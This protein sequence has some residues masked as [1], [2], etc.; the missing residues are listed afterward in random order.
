MIFIRKKAVFL[1]DKLSLGLTFLLWTTVSVAQNNLGELLDAGA[2]RLSADEFRQEV[3]QQPMQGPTIAGSGTME[4][5]FT[6]SGLVQGRSTP[7]YIARPVMVGF[8]GEWTF[9]DDGTV[10]T[11]MRLGGGSSTAVVFPRRC[12]FWFKLGDQYFF[13]DSDTDRSARV[14][15]RTIVK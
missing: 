7:A 11:T 1:H 15:S 13:S 8:Q 2:K 6:T 3:V 5:M 10:C 12:Q 4:V 9:G 14:F